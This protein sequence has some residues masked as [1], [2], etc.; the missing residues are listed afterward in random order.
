MKRAIIF[1]LG[2]LFI[3]LIIV[4]LYFFIVFMPTNGIFKEAKSVMSGEKIVAEDNIL[5][6]YNSC[7]IHFPEVVEVD[8]NIRREWVWHD[9]K[10]G[11]MLVRYS[12]RYL[13][14]DGEDVARMLNI[15][16]KWIIERVDGHWE[17]VDILE[18]P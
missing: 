1:L 16:S 13:N 4:G 11:Y 18:G 7:E 2:I 14:E 6:R 9:G 5:S 10:K 8:C 12:C 15:E 3:I 17:I